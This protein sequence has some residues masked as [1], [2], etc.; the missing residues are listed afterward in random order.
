LTLATEN[1][2]TEMVRL[3]VASGADLNAK[4]GFGLTAIAIASTL[5]DQ[6][7]WLTKSSSNF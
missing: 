2:Q 3:L 5:K 6:Q 4:T 1:S 7:V